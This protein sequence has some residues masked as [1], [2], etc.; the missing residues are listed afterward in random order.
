L[1]MPK[2]KATDIWHDL[3]AFEECLRLAAEHR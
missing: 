2:H 1:V 3:T